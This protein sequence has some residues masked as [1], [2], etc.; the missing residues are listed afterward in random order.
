[1]LGELSETECEDLADKFMRYGG[2]GSE[3]LLRV[4][5]PRLKSETVR[6]C[7]LG[8]TEAGAGKWVHMLRGNT[9]LLYKKAI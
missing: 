1:M 3:E 6:K 7:V 8:C 5:L 9:T 2:S 4:L